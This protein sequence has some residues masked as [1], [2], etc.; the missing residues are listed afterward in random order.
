MTTTGKV[1]TCLGVGCLATVAAV[2]IALVAGVRW[3]AE[4]PEGVEVTVEAPLQV[5]VG[6]E[7]TITATLRNVDTEPRRLVDVDVADEYLAGIA[8]RSTAPAF[9]SSS[10]VPIDGTVSYSFDLDLPAGSDTRVTFTAVATQSGDWSGDFD[11]CI[12]SQVKCVPHLV[13]TLVA[14][15]GGGL[16]PE[17]PVEP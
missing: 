16:P 13:R 8:V 15:P 14:E 10:H 12:D 1:L 2:V 17:S 4:D 6:E 7:L 9:V 11:F 5:M 3:L